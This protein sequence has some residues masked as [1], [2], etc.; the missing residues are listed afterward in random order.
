MIEVVVIGAG[1]RGYEAYGKIIKERKDIKV[2]GVA[3]PDEGKRE[4]FVKEHKIPS[5]RVFESWEKLLKLG[6]I[7][8]AAIIATPDRLHVEPAVAFMEKG[9]HLLLEKPIAPTRDGVKKVV[10]T[11]HKTKRIVVVGHVLRYTPFFKKLKE[12]IEEKAIGKVIGIEHKEN[13]GFYH[14]AHSFVRGNWRNTETSSPSILAK[15]CHDLDILYWLIDAKCE[16]LSSF[17]ELS[18]FKR[19]NQPEGAADRCLDC[20]EEIEKKCPYSAKKLYLTNYTGWPVSV[21]SLDLSY[22]GRLKALKEGPY[23]RCVFA[24]DNN[25]VDHQ[26]V[27][28]AFEDGTKVTFTMTAFTDTITRRIRIFGTLGEIR[29]EFEKGEIEV[30]RFSE[31]KR[32]LYEVNAYFPETGHGGG[33]RGIIDYFVSV[34]SGKEKADYTLID[35]SAYSHFMAFTAEDSRLTNGKVLKVET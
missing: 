16:Y 7:A 24:C 23:G 9:Y 35:E 2:V 31:E 10:D 28:M 13:V 20:P 32:D 15:S 14:F 3:E 12:L 33:D 8:D 5:E 26:T 17:G 21:I 30:I 25:V 22:E 29:G 6:K 4:R 27:N 18:F 11:A 34:I 1:N 19:E